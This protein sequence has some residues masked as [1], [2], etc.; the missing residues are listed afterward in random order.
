[1]EIRF[2]KKSGGGGIDEGIAINE[3]VK[4]LKE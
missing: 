3:H 4:A 1:M 2:G